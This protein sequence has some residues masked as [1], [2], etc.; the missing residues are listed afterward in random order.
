M[1]REVFSHFIVGQRTSTYVMDLTDQSLIDMATAK[2]LF[3][4]DA[5][6]NHRASPQHE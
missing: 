5:I 3:L 2:C 1:R 4:Y 6:V